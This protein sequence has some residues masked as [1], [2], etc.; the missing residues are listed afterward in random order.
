MAR[1][2]TINISKI[3]IAMHRPHSPECYMSLFRSAY[4]L[5]RPIRQGDLHAIMLGS[6]YHVDPS[7]PHL[8]LEGEIYRFVKID[9]TEPWFNSETNEQASEEEVQQINIP[10][11]LV[12]H[13][14][15]IPFVFTPDNHTLWF[16]C[17]DRKDVLSPGA[18]AIFFNTLFSAQEISAR[19][20]TVEV[21]PFV[22]S[23]RLED[24][25]NQRNIEKMIIEFKRPNSDDGIDLEARFEERMRQQNIRKQV[26]E[27]LSADGY[28]SL[29][30]ET[31]AEAMV[32]ANN[33]K[34]VIT[35]RSP[36]GTRETASTMDK[37]YVQPH[38][39]DENIE[40]RASVLK[41]AANIG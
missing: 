2:R 21:T 11:N 9:P 33:G 39:V 16:I 41:R 8:G 38:T 14:R 30:D 22:D 3:N 7:N 10:A 17:R 32:A 12:P 1:T 20:P 19:F 15:K 35:S 5:K 18:A 6:L 13:L 28:L 37:P 26:T 24:M 36:L 34:V 31:K 25:L 29:D 4:E 40:T 27:I 23:E